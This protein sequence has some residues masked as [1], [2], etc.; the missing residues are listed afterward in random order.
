[1]VYYN[2]ETI[3]HYIVFT[4]TGEICR[5][6]PESKL[7]CFNKKQLYENLLECYLKKNMKI[8]C[9]ATWLQ[10]STSSFYPTTYK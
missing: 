5:S 3:F 9:T 8:W 10:L 6:L 7:E 1:M 4:G 2:L